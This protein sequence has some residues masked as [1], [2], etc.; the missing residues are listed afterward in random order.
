DAQLRGVNHDSQVAEVPGRSVIVFQSDLIVVTLSLLDDLG[1]A[2]RRPR[3]VTVRALWGQRLCVVTTVAANNMG[4]LGT[5]RRSC[6]GQP[7][8]VMRVAGEKCMGP[9]AGLR[10]G[11]IDL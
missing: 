8:V 10:T 1:R 7:L 5:V 6:P 3:D 4:D 2:N 9:D 11:H